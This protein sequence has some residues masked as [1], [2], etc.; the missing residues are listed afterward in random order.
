V[1]IVVAANAPYLTH[2]FSAN[3]ILQ[4][5]GLARNVR[6]GLLPG[7]PTIDP[8]FGFVSQAVGHRAA[9]DWLHGH[10]PWWN[11]YE[12]VGMPLAGNMQSGAFF[13][14]I[15]LLVFPNGLLYAHLLLEILTGIATYLL[16]RKVGLSRWPATAAGAAFALN[17]TF[18]WFG[19]APVQPIAFLPLTLLGLEYA[20]EAAMARRRMGWTVLAVA[21]ALSLYAGFP[22]TAFID[23]VL[24]GLWLVVRTVQIRGRDSWRFLGKAALGAG[25]GLLLAAPIVVAFLDDIHH[26]NVGPHGGA[27]AHAS[28]TPAAVAPLTMPYFF[29]PIFGVASSDPRALQQIILLWSNVGGYLTT[30]AVLLAVVGLLGRKDRGLRVALGAWVLFAVA[31]TYGASWSFPIVNAIPGISRT[32]FYRYSPASW[33]FAVVVLAAHGIDDLV[34]SRATLSQRLL[35][36]VGAA[37][38]AL[39]LV[40]LGLHTGLSVSQQLK[41][42]HVHLWRDASIVWGIAIVV[43][44]VVAA[45]LPRRGRGVLLAAILVVDAAAMFVVPEFSAPR[46]GTVD[47]A[48]IAFLRDHVGLQRVFALGGPLQPNYGSY[49]GVPEINTNDLP[50]PQQWT[51]Y[52]GTRLDTTVI[53]TIFTGSSSAT[54]PQEQLMKHLAAYQAIGVKYVLAAGAISLPAPL[55]PVWS[56]STLTVYEVPDPA[57]YFE[58]TSGS[59]TLAPQSRNSVVASCNSPSILVRRELNEPGWRAVAGSRT[60]TVTGYQE[61]FQAVHLPAGRTAVDFEFSPPHTNLALL[62]GLAGLAGLIVSALLAQRQRRRGPSDRLVSDGPNGAHEPH[63]PHEPHERAVGARP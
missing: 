59:C 34:Q 30:S 41:A 57:P 52:I 17:G 48:P 40:A 62:A 3:P 44:V 12:G 43:V 13:P 23:G 27:L 21:V 5:S 22:E 47:T 24:V 61:L 56:D 53:P 33:E 14:L 4:V 15:V 18:S 11:P 51:D 54:G 9:I 8:N 55:L 37:A 10:V 20:R 63:E 60:F 46:A 16:L 38:A 2:V 42:P 45:L 6:P 1:A 29:G 50:I 7:A 19:H 58:V 26:A 49:F 28:L 32:A 31:R 39:A 25:T 35:T 36:V